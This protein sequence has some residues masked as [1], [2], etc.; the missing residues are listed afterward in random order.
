MIP[1]FL[2]PTDQIRIV[3]PSGTVTPDFIDGAKKMLTSWGLTATEG[4]YARSEYGRFAG[5]KEQRVVDLQQALDDPNVK[6]ILCSRGGYGLAQIIDRLD[7]TTFKKSPKWLIGFSDISI[8][9][10]VITNL[11]VASIH[12]VMSKYFT[13][14]PADA[15]QIQLIKDI[16]FGEFPVY[17][18]AKHPLNRLGQVTGKLIGGNLSVLI[19]LRGSQFD[20]QFK[21]NILF[22]EDVGEKP[23]H[24]DRLMQNLRLSG[25]L[26]QIS[27]LVVGRFSECVE[28]PLM[29]KSIAEL[30]SDA[31]AGYDY[32][33]CFD[34]PAGHVDYNLPLIL[35]MPA[36]LNVKEVGVDLIY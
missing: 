13:E 8:L 5:T 28:D 14:L 21:D 15:D 2:Q 9:H 12:G 18:F 4:Q 25:A 17:M 20:M 10:N 30:I 6:A 29:K 35:G 23:Y 36:N 19:G 22:L 24:I 11:G 31:V 34:F 16:L 3:S 1:P 33:V 32:P 7:F 26:A 27:G